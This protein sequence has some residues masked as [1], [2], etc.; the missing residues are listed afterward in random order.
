MK[1]LPITGSALSTPERS[2]QELANYL[3]SLGLKCPPK[4]LQQIY[5]ELGAMIGRW[6]QEQ[7][8]METEAVANALLSLRNRLSEVI[9]S[10][11]GHRAGF[12]ELVHIEVVSQLKRSL[13]ND[14]GLGSLPDA[15]RSI[16]SFVEE[17]VRIIGHCSSAYA[18][19]TSTKGPSGRPGLGWYDGFTH[20]VMELA[21][22]AGVRPTI[23][24]DRVS[25]ERS[26]W[27]LTV[28]GELEKFLPRPMRSPSAEARAKRLERS[29]RKLGAGQRQ[30]GS[31]S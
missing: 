15:D 9:N 7:E 14:S 25:G 22:Q 10:L 18:D 20:V 24:T 8:S 3:K 2:K 31:A 30:K 28:A 16:D 5:Q 11:S 1:R 12:R 29:K 23:S 27:I 19:L 26:G 4:R 6:W 17:A 21:R 13:A